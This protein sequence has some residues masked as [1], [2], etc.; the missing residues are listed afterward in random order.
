MFSSY[1]ETALNSSIGESIFVRQWRPEGDIRGGALLSHGVFEHSGRYAHVAERLV[2]H[3]YACWALDHYGHGKSPGP[4][5]DIQS[6]DHFVDDTGIVIGALTKEIEGKPI[7]LG[8]SMGGAIAALYAVRHQEML[9]ALVLSSPAL[10]ALA[11]PAMIALGRMLSFVRPSA[12]APAGL[13]QPAT[14]N[15]E[16]ETWKQN[17]PLKHDR[18]TLRLAAFIVDA[19]EEARRRASQLTIPVLL[20]VAGEDTYVDMRGSQ[21]FYD[22]LS[23]DLREIHIYP[24]YYHEVFNELEREKPL[25]D[26]ENWLDRLDAKPTHS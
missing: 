22:R 3:G 26:L 7:L 6:P 13:S 8:H 12:Q 24:G 4:R 17:D 18:M 19:G 2:K 20:L 23:P 15:T 14:H 21:E 1:T 16:W 9:R 5:G 11:S 25:G 10:K